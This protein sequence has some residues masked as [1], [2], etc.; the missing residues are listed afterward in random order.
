MVA[1]EKPDKASFVFNTCV[2]HTITIDV[3][4]RAPIDIGP[5][6]KATTVAIKIAAKCQAAGFNPSGAGMN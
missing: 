4:E 1:L 3:K 6:I 5:V 2:R